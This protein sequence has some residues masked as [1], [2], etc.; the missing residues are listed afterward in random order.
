M[1]GLDETEPPFKRVK[2]S[3]VELDSISNKS[4]LQASIVNLGGPMARPLPSLVKEDMVGSN[5]VIK[6]VEFIRII[7]KALYSL[8]YEK[9][10]KVLEE[11]SGINL[12][13]STVSHF[14]KQI[15]DGNWDES[16]ATLQ[17][18]GL[19]EHILKSAS[20]LIWEYKF[21]NHLEKDEVMDALKTLRSEIA[22]LKINIKRLHELSSCVVSSSRHGILGFAN[23]DIDSEKLGLKLLEELHKIF[24]PS[25]MIPER[26]LENLVEQAL[27]LQ[28]E[29]CFLHNSLDKS[30]SLYTDHQCGKDQIPS[31]T[32]QVLR[33]HDNEVW[34]LQ[35]SHEGKYLAS[36]SNDKS[37]IIWEVH[38]DAEVLLKH[39]LNGH[40]KPVV[41]VAWSP[42][43][44]FLLSCGME[45]AIRCWDVHLGVCLRVY[46]K[47]GLGLISCVWSPDGKQFFSGVTDRSISLW[48]L[49]GNEVE[50]WKGQRTTKNSD[51]AVTKDGRYIITMCREM[52]ILLLDRETRIEKL[53]EEDQIVTSFSLS[54]DEKFLLVNILSQEIHLWSIADT[55]KLV[56]KYEGHKRSRFVIRSCFGGFDEYF[57][58]SGSEDSQVYIWH[59]KTGSLI[60]ALPGH[61]GA[62]NCVS[63]NPT[64][65]HML[66]SGSDDHTIR[67]WGIKRVNL[68]RKDTLSNGFIHQ[69]NGINK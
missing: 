68:K 53:I 47:C 58:A 31:K 69:C 52:T 62:V 12:Y 22:P 51:M 43:N 19:D 9:S 41:T 42:D 65:P 28:R 35:F 13:S 11:E 57:I 18:I 14:R 63:W 1:G 25:V 24:P 6:K 48:D 60:Q 45:E 34:C 29:T 21:L 2:G 26:R 54:K 64:N 16:V 33:G 40:Q 61:S 67:I 38:D 27:C 20:F 3:S 8:G 32:L 15:L 59:R 37:V 56:M 30:L 49:E 7:T 66:A 17:K 50:C 44:R 46:E 10:G 39:T 55:P 23:M 5:G 4:S 36:S